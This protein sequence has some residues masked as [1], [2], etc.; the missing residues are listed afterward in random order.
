MK[1]FAMKS[2]AMKTRGTKSASTRALGASVLVA[3]AVFA[4]GC[5]R[6]R[7]G[8]TS[9][10]GKSPT[11]SAY[12]NAQ[13]E[14]GE[15]SAERPLAS[16]QAAMTTSSLGHAWYDWTSEPIAA[17][18]TSGMQGRLAQ[19]SPGGGQAYPNGEAM[20]NDDSNGAAP[21]VSSVIPGTPRMAAGGGTGSP[22]STA[23]GSGQTGRDDSA[24]A[25]G[26]T[27]VP[28]GSSEATTPRGTAEER[29]AAGVEAIE[30]RVAREGHAMGHDM[31]NAG[32]QIGDAARSTAAAVGQM[33][34]ETVQDA[35]QPGG[36]S[37]A[38]PPVRDLYG[39]D[40]D[41]ALGERIR[42][43]LDANALTAHAGE[44]VHLD[45][46]QGVV[47]VTGVVMDQHDRLNLAAVIANVAGQGQVRD[48]MSVRVLPRKK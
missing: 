31:Q 26:R 13:V 41:K 27:A 5:E 39:T 29:D 38:T 3:A 42:M 43:A 14:P 10:G 35:R 46:D 32:E 19:G 11:E 17:A 7:G 34:K 2:F 37:E 9:E 45:V 44:L 22:S 25:M 12:S 21:P 24:S 8:Y 30:D 23:W 33:A 15:E 48:L 1:S 28:G 18:G 4:A 36:P 20:N 6:D 47:T 16:E 40:A